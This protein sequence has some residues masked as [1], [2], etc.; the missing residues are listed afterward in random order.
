MNPESENKTVHVNP[1]V[2]GKKAGP[3]IIF[4]TIVEYSNLLGD[5][6]RR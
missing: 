2:Y 1:C 4:S 6:V 5:N 3:N